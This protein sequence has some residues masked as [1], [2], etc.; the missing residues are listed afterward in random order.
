LTNTIM[1]PLFKSEIHQQ[2]FD[3]NGFVKFPSLLSPGQADELFRLYNT[4]LDEHNKI[5]IPFITTS[6]SNNHDLIRKVDEMIIGILGPEVEKILTNYKLLFSN[7]LI[8][9]KGPDSETGAH[10]D[11]NFVDE[12]NFDSI[13]IWVPLCDTDER[14][15]SMRFVPGSHKFMFTL[16]PTHSYPWA[17]ALVQQQVEQHLISFPCKKGD[18]FIFHHGIIHASY[19]NLTDS[20]RVA[21]VLAAYP[22]KAE[23]IHYFLPSGEKTQVSKYK[24]TKE[25]FL[26]FIKEQP[27]AMGEFLQYEKFDFKQVTPQEFEGFFQKV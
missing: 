6:H 23:L 22:E 12:N 24:M 1:E 18:G 4:T 10:Q 2:E 20:P 21:A 8:K 5:G 7:F 27:P 16:R 13:S 9:T 15:G 17:Y 26:H 14:N 3:K 19:P 11:I 25:A